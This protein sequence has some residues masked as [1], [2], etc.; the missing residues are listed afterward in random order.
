[1]SEQ[2]PKPKQ[3]QQKQPK[4]KPAAGEQ[5]QQTSAP[6]KQQ[7]Q[8]QQPPHQQNQTSGQPPS[9]TSTNPFNQLQRYQYIDN[10]RT[11]CSFFYLYRSFNSSTRSH[12]TFILYLSNLA[13]ILTEDHYPAL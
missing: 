9:S 12:L 4:P 3:K 13:L 2:P 10:I 8:A 5:Q 11:V 6:P 7:K 1:M